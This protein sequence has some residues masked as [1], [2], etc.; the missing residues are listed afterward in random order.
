MTI[1]FDTI[2]SGIR[3]PSNNIE[4]NTRMAVHSLPA[5][6]KKLVLVGQKLKDAVTH[7]ITTAYAVGAVVKPATPNGHL[8]F[9]ITAGT[10]GGS[11]PTWP[12]TQGGE[13]TDGTVV[14]K[15]FAADATLTAKLNVKQCF[16]SDDA[17]VYN[18][19]G[20]MLHRMAIAAL[21]TNPYLNLYTIAEDDASGVHA[22]GTFTV[23]GTPTGSG[24]I[25]AYIGK[26]YV[27]ASFTVDDTVTTIA[28]AIKAAIAAKPSLP[29]VG[30]SSSGVVTAVYKH[31]GTVGNQYKLAVEYTQDAGIAVAAAGLASGATDP[32]IHAAGSILDKIAPSRYHRIAPAYN[33]AT[34]LGYLKT[35]ADFVSNAIEKRSAVVCTALVD[36][37]A[38][39]QTAAGGLNHGRTVLALVKA[40]KAPACELAAAIGAIECSFA[41]PAL[42]RNDAAVTAAATAVPTDDFTNTEIETC[43]HNGITPL[44]AADDGGIL[45]SRMITTF[46]TDASLLDVTTIDSLD[47]LRDVMSAAHRAFKG[48]KA[49]DRTLDALLSITKGKLYDLEEAEILRDIDDYIE[50]VKLEPGDEAGEYRMEIPAPVVPGLHVLNEKIIL[51][52]N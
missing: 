25:R 4:F 7:A 10:S 21:N 40:N 33:D 22:T 5:N 46:Q 43:L 38:N 28:T 11:A 50:E 36:T 9:C 47:Y 14:W 2:P 30:S 20:S 52:L 18:G 42:P 13:V 31:A 35:H 32:D 45:V 8:Y 51:H 41:D 29:V 27:D 19:Y 6:V 3:R 24:T 12:T 23:T 34:T 17:A 48:M 26:E 16:S 37:I 1:S 15:E 49:T 44:Y 39:A